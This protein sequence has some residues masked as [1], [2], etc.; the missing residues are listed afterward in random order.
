MDKDPA[1]GKLQ[2]ASGVQHRAVDPFPEHLMQQ[3]TGGCNSAE[4]VR[5]PEEGPARLAEGGSAEQ[6]RQ[7]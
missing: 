3:S 2:V 6:E 4:E 1:V 5:N 7:P